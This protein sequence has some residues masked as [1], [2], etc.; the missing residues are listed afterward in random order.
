[1]VTRH[2]D[3]G[4]A[5]G[6]AGEHGRTGCSGDRFDHQDII[7]VRSLDS[8]SGSTQADAADWQGLS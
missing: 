1:M 5:K 2:D 8:G 3:R 6:I 7:T 4:G